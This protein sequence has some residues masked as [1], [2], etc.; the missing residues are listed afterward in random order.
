MIGHLKHL[1]HVW[2]GATQ[3]AA[4]GAPSLD[5]HKRKI[6]RR[7]EA[8]AK[9]LREVDMIEAKLRELDYKEAKL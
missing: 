1:A 9:F 8:K 6:H 7:E 3:S 4:R 5:Q 2:V